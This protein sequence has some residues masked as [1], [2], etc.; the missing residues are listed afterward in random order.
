MLADWWGFHCNKFIYSPNIFYLIIAKTY[1]IN[2]KIRI[3]HLPIPHRRPFGG[4]YSYN[5]IYFVQ[6]FLH[7]PYMIQAIRFPYKFY[8]HFHR[9]HTNFAHRK[10][11]YR[12]QFKSHSNYPYNYYSFYCFYY[13]IVVIGVLNCNLDYKFIIND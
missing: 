4:I 12:Y 7:L 9:L 3:F 11:S 5:V 10:Y 2:I 6:K 13:G 1:N 8:P